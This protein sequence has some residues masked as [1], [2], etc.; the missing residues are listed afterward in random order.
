MDLRL[1]ITAL[2]LACN[3][4][5]LIWKAKT[6]PKGRAPL[7]RGWIDGQETPINEIVIRGAQ[8][9]AERGIDG[10]RSSLKSDLEKPG[11]KLERR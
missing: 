6:N 2:L 10:L 4:G 3:A 7:T 5:Y 11:N 8:K 9:S 1:L